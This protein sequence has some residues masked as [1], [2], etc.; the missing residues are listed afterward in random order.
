MP[1]PVAALI[2]ASLSATSLAA[3]ADGRSPIFDGHDLKGWH[4]SRTTA[5]GSTGD[6]RVEDGAIALRQKPYGQGGLLLTDKRYKDFDLYLEVLACQGCNSGIFF[7]STESGSAYQI[8]LVDG[9]LRATAVLDTGSLIG[10][11]MRVSVPVPFPD[12]TGI[13]KSGEW[14]SMRLKV[15]GGGTPHISLWVNGVHQWDVQETQNNQ[16]AG[17]TDGHIGLQLHW[18]ATY[19][20]AIAG[21]T[22]GPT[23]KPG[24]AIRFRNIAL[25]ELP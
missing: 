7:H 4:W 22:I 17:E 8:E 9:P 12:L 19:E 20:P 10:E 14:N 1:L 3:T 5:H 21:S 11:G 18:S 6:A 23:W 24:E 15:E 13:W 16:I 25:K 2:A